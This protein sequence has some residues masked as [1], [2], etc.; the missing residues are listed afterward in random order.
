MSKEII[1]IF[2]DAPQVFVAITRL[3]RPANQVKA[4]GLFQSIVL[5]S[6]LVVCSHNVMAAL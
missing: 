1:H 4:T 2:R 5:L 3:E 6:L